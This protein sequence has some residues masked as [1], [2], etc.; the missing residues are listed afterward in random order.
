MNGLSLVILDYKL[1]LIIYKINK[2][3]IKHVIARGF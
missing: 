1:F 2:Q 3:T